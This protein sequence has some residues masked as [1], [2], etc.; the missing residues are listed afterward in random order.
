MLYNN[1]YTLPPK[2]IVFK[3]WKENYTQMG[4][5]TNN[6]MEELFIEVWARV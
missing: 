3:S 4:L 5:T 2:Y 1:V 6:L